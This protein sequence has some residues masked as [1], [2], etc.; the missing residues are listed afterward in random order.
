MICTNVVPYL[1]IGLA[2]NNKIMFMFVLFSRLFGHFESLALVVM[3]YTLA[4]FD[5]NHIFFKKMV[6]QSKNGKLY[7]FNFMAK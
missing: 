1:S 5:G 2:K 3:Y 4:H 7:I 6:S